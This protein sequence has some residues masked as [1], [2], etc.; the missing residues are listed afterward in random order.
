MREKPDSVV[1]RVGKIINLA[2]FGKGILDSR[3]SS[4]KARAKNNL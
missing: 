1:W 4:I 2:S 3:W